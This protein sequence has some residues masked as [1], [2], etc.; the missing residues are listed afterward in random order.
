MRSVI[1]DVAAELGMSTEIAVV[2]LP[3]VRNASELFVCNSLIGIWPVRTIDGIGNYAVG[4]V[5]RALV[6][7]LENFPD[8][9]QDRWYS[10]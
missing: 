1:L 5:T 3:D 2:N 8:S 7:A 6:E 10:S 9:G 4:G